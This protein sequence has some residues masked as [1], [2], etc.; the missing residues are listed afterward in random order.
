MVAADNWHEFIYHDESGTQSVTLIAEAPKPEGTRVWMDSNTYT[1]VLTVLDH[2]AQ[3]LHT[4]ASLEAEERGVEPQVRAPLPGTVTAIHI[5]D[6]SRVT[7][8][9]T[10][11]TIEAMKME[12]PLKAP[13]DGIVTVHVTDAQQVK[14]D[15]N[16]LT[17]TADDTEHGE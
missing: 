16:I 1:G 7:A 3:V 14:L 17:V 5:P 11:V 9:E 2:R 6:G 10:V 12:H 8:G 13:L 15:Q 4:L